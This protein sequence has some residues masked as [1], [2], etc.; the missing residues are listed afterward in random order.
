MG[1]SPLPAALALAFVLAV[2]APAPAALADADPPSDVIIGF[3]YYVPFKRPDDAHEKQLRALMKIVNRRS[4]QM[5]TVII[6]DRSDLGAIPG[7]FGKPQQ[8][9]DILNK[10]VRTFFR[11]RKQDP[12]LVIVM[13]A[14]F[15]LKGGRD[16]T[17]AATAALQKI[18]I[19][20]DASGNELTSAAVEAVHAVAK[21]NGHPLPDVP[22]A[23]ASSSTA[24]KGAN[25]AAVVII[26][27]LAIITVASLVA[28][29]VL[30]KRPAP[31]P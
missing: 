13:Q 1:G 20:P 27:T 26:A 22:L 14:G 10:E 9:A 18:E 16:A 21:A 3:D 4:E 29:L 7:F 12:T 28:L 15:A 23:G 25:T 11:L 24:S 8:Y 6:A 31:D 17:P 5:R 30:R 19:P 2:L